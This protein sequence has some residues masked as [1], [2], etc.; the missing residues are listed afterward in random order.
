MGE[1]PRRILKFWEN[2]PQGAKIGKNVPQGPKIMG[3]APQGPKK[4]W[5]ITDFR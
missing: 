1:M 3:Y 2:A 4:Q 5:E